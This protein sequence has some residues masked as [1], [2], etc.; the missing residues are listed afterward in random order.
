M[1]TLRT[2][3]ITDFNNQGTEYSVDSV[4]L[5]SAGTDGLTRYT[6]DFEKWMGYYKQTPDFRIVVNKFA[7]W[8]FGR[9]IKADEK[10]QAKLDKIKGWGK[11]SARSVLKNQW[12]T[13]MI[14]GDSFA[15]IIKDNQGRLTNLKPLGKLTIVMNSEGIIIG[16]EQHGKEKMYDTEDIFH[17]SYERIADEG[18]GIPF[19]EAL[20]PIILAR[21]GLIKDLQEMYHQTVFPTNIFEAETDDTTKLTSITTTLN[22]AY[23]KHENIV[24][25]AGVFR[26]IKRVSSPQQ[27]GNADGA[28][29]FLKF[30]AREFVTSCGMPEIILGWA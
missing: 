21:N 25:P 17:L 7:S 28:L 12:R 30:L 9:G 20:E 19:M 15:H 4:T 14:T 5:D 24:I 16:Y 10:N 26:E 6:P 8:T 1:A 29:E 18:H 23:K 13:A 2:G 11:D 22:S 3:Q 27:S